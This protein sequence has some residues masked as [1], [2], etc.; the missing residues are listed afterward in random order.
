MDTLEA[1]NF[2]DRESPESYVDMNSVD[3]FVLFVLVLWASDQGGTAAIMVTV[4]A[5]YCVGRVIGRIAEMEEA[6]KKAAEKAATPTT[7]TENEADVQ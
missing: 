6:K 4:Y 3:K 5:L 7:E 1:A 2:I